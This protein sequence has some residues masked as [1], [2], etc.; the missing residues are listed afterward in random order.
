MLLVDGAKRVLWQYPGRVPRMPFNFDD[1]TFFG[2]RFDRII[3]NQEDQDTIQILTFPGGRLVWSYGV[4]GVKGSSPGYLH[5]PDDAYLLPNGLRSV[6]DAYNCRVV[7][8]TAAHRIARPYGRAASATTTRRASS[9]RQRRDA[10][11]RRRHACER[12]RRLLDRRHRRRTA[13]ALGVR[14]PVSYPSD[15][16]LLGPAGSS[17]PTTRSPAGAHHD[18]PRPRALAVRAARRGRARSTIRRSRCGS[19]RA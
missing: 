14:A 11:A 7:F 10:A 12:D 8:L 1:D 18:E 5:T 4:V 15:A 16:Q 13:A 3:S 2:P 17:S 19:R 9:G 6:A